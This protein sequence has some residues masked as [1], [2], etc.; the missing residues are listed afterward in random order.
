MSV[1][2]KSLGFIETVGLAAAIAA[3]D[4][5]LKSANVRLVGRE[6]S[7]GN[8]CIT[9][10]IAGDI[11]AVNAAL[12]AAKAVCEKVN[13]VWAMAAI[14]RP[15]TG[16]DEMFV[17]PEEEP[18]PEPEKEHAP[19]EEAPKIQELPKVEETPQVGEAPKIEIEEAPEVVESSALSV[20]V[21]EQSLVIQQPVAP[22][23]EPKVVPPVLPKKMPAKTTGKPKKPGKR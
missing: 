17:R 13:R 12:M 5:A 18:K 1:Q 19:E 6:N 7:K 4:A 22:P 10:K 9:I 8:G 16:I 2:G 11:G 3:A 23:V 14:A 20:S 15:A 21:V